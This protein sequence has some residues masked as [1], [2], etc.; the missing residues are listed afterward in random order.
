MPLGGLQHRRVGGPHPA[1]EARLA[2]AD[3]PAREEDR[4]ERRHQRHGDDERARQGQDHGQRHRHEHLA[5]HALQR[6]DRHVDQDDDRHREH[7]GLGHLGGGVADQVRGRAVR[8][9]AAGAQD[10]LDHHHRAVDDQAEIDGAEA[11]QVA[12]QAEQ[13]H[14]GEGHQHRERDRGRHDQPGAEVAQQQQQDDDDE[15][16]ALEEVV[17]DG[18]DR[19]VHERAAV[20]VGHDLHARR[21][22]WAQVVDR[23][24]DLP[25]HR[26]GILPELHQRDAHD[27]LAL[28]VVRHGPEPDLRRLHHLSQRPERHRHAARAGGDH[29]VGDV[30]RPLGEAEAADRLLLVVVLDIGA[31]AGGVVVGQRREDLGEADAVAAERVGRDPDLVG[32]H[33]AAVDVDVGDAGGELQLRRDR[34]LQGAAELHR[35]VGGP[36]Q[37]ELVDLAEAGRHRAHLRVADACRHHALGRRQALEHLTARLGDRHPVREGDVDRRDPGP[38]GRADPGQARRP[39]HGV[40]HREG[41]EPLD[42]QRAEPR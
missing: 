30:L 19:A 32:R 2:L 36:A 18:A 26:A 7:H 40:L 3:T 5:G 11:H 15:H 16:R 41:D 27:R 1:D 21:Q 13:P 42:L 17:L 22:L 24:L 39:R 4:G 29:D 9:L 23:L 20:V 28:R 8:A 31:P 33:L 34:P 12:R 6:E 10:V 38:R 35:R 14:A 37:L 25:D